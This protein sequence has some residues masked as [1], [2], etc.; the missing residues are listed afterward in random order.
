[1]VKNIIHI[2][3]GVTLSIFWGGGNGKEAYCLTLKNFF[4]A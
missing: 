4:F 3:I 1:M 2:N